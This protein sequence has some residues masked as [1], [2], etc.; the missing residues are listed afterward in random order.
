[1]QAQ[2]LNAKGEEVG[3][4]ELQEAIFAQKASKEFLHEYVTVYEA[5]QREGSANTK[6]KSEVSGS[7]KKPWKHDPF[8]AVAPRR[9]HFRPEGGQGE[10]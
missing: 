7:G 4:V 6:T 2:L 5:N 10:A 3:K 8:A 1:M 9:R